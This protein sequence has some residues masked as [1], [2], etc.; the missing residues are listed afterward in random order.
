M[1]PRE[2][3]LIARPDGTNRGKSDVTAR[4]YRS[5]GAVM[6]MA[7]FAVLAVNTP[8]ARS[9]IELPASEVEVTFPTSEETYPAIEYR[10]KK[11][12]AGKADWRV[13]RQS[14]NC[15][16]N[17]LAGGP[18]GRLYDFGGTYI[19]FTDDLGKSW[20]SVRPLAPLVNGEGTIV[21]AP[22]GDVLGIGWD[23]Y[24]GDHLQSFKYDA[25]DKEWV[26]AELP[27]HT[28]FF[29]REWLAVVPGPVHFL[30]NKHEYVV[31]LKGAWPSKEVWFYS[32]DGVNY[33]QA[34]SKM[35]EKYASEVHTKWLKPK[36]DKT[37]DWYQPNTN[38][39][40]APLGKG[41]AIAA[42][43]F[44]D[45]RDDWAIFDPKNFRWQPLSIPDFEFTG[46]VL[47]DSKGRLHELIADGGQFVY[48]I[49]TD[50]GRSWNDLK[51][52]LPKDLG[53][54]E[55][56]FKANAQ[57][58]FAAV[59]F[60]VHDNK[61]NED[62]DV[63]YKIDISR[64]SPRLWRFYEVGL[65]DL[66]VSSGVGANLRFDFETVAILPNGSV[67]VSFVDSKSGTATRATPA[68]AI[69]MNPTKPIARRR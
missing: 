37:A 6:A 53:I 31:F 44:P 64:D 54:E 13:V 23:P 43:D 8:T 35:V 66:N 29:D 34:S 52:S 38:G 68:V 39:N 41:V 57:V 5:L 2:A 11:E 69:E 12:V 15:C 45:I 36:S 65:G 48:R 24:S 7:L 61:T 32:F 26:Y 63:L 47:A 46:R 14:G 16:E 19:N 50:G 18:N 55:V 4:W 21:L 51:V 17:Y 42:P 9:V 49:S 1:R 67:A 22:N 30:G 56:D 33:T 58:G 27:V 28:P 10:G 62:K 20:K 3:N 25:G 40:V 59:A 60:H